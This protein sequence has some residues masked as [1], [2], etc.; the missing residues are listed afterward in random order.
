MGIERVTPIEAH[1]T[2]RSKLL[3]CILIIEHLITCLATMLYIYAHSCAVRVTAFST[4]VELV[5]M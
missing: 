3:N 2:V 1:A 4:Q 5:Y